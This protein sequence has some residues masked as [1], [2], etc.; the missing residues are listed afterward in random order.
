MEYIYFARYA[1]LEVVFLSSFPWE[2]I[3]SNK[4]TTEP[5]GKIEVTTSLTIMAWF[6][7]IEYLCQYSQMTTDF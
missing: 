1:V 7:I 4:K 5:S 6:A 3:P 2:R